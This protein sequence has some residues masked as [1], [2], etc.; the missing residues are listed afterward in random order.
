MANSFCCTAKK[1]EWLW[2]SELISTYFFFT[3][4]HSKHYM[5]LYIEMHNTHTHTYICMY[6]ILT[7][8]L[9]SS[10]SNLPSSVLIDTTLIILHNIETILT[11]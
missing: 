4:N 10:E 7:P 3:F 5:K 11:L 8:K 1:I 6:V 2:S 9:V